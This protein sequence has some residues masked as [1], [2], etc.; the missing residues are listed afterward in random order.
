MVSLNELYAQDNAVKDLNSLSNRCPELESL[1]IRNNRLE[2]SSDVAAA[3][4][5]CPSIRDIW[6]EGNQCCFSSRY[7]VIDSPIML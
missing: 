2:S 4:A 6:I 3:L 7:E 5:Q 1:D